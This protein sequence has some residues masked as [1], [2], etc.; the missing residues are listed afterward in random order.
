MGPRVRATLLGWKLWAM[1]WR[2]YVRH[3]INE[4][5]DAID[6]RRR[7]DEMLEDSGLRSRAEE[8]RWEMD[9]LHKKIRLLEFEIQ[10]MN[11]IAPGNERRTEAGCIGGYFRQ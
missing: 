11:Q 7:I 1:A 10:C 2:P 5:L 4:S 9:D 3:A 6:D 8:N